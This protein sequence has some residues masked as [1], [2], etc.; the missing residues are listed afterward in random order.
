VWVVIDENLTDAELLNGGP[1][2]LRVNREITDAL[3][4]AGVDLFPYMTYT[5]PSERYLVVNEEE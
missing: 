5:K 1:T 3:R 2:W 4:S